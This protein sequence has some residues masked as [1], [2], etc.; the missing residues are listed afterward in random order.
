MDS[1]A[2]LQLV[3]GG[4]LVAVIAAG[5]KAYNDIRAG[6]VAGRKSEFDSL[7]DVLAEQRA[8]MAD[9]AKRYDA[10][11]TD[12]ETDLRAAEQRARSAE[13]TALALRRHVVALEA[14]LV[15]AGIDVPQWQ[16]P[17]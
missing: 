16:E 5:V 10:R 9:Q 11:I 14:A 3:L 8:E 2:V 7:R 1:D 6:R 12:L 15:R 4:G 17:T 13:A